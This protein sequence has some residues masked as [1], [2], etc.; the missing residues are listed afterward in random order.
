MLFE[1]CPLSQITKS[2]QINR[3][4]QLAELSR[5]EFD[6]E[7]FSHSACVKLFCDICDESAEFI[8]LQQNETIFKIGN[9]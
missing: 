1:F 4:A 9:G 6:P 7:S 3:P 8:I 2:L 5:S